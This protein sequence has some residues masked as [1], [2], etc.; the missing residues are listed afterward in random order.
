MLHRVAQANAASEANALMRIQ[1]QQQQDRAA[2]EARAASHANELTRLQLRLQL[3]QQTAVA[4]TA[5]I[6]QQHQA[7]NV[8]GELPL[9]PEQALK[10]ARM[11]ENLVNMCLAI[12]DSARPDAGALHEISFA[13]DGM[14]P[15]P[16]PL[17][18]HPPHSAAATAPR[19][20]LARSDADAPRAGGGSR[21]NLHSTFNAAAFALRAASDN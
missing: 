19:P 3:A 18:D 13:I 6:L 1:L 21:I 14:A 9:N 20:E 5:H 12:G 4:G 2:D 15:Y 11:Q 7:L 16:P 10:K 8:L 17:V